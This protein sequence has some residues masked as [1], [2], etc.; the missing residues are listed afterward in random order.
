MAEKKGFSGLNDIFIEND[1][2]LPQNDDYKSGEQVGLFELDK[3]DIQGQQNIEATA[4]SAQA[5]EIDQIQQPSVQDDDYI[6][7]S[8]ANGQ[9]PQNDEGDNPKKGCLMMVAFIMFM[10]VALGVWASSESGSGTKPVNSQK[11][12]SD[13]NISKSQGKNLS[14]EQEARKRKRDFI[15]WVDRELKNNVHRDIG[16][17]IEATERES[18]LALSGK[19]I[20][21]DL[22]GGKKSYMT[23]KLSKRIKWDE[24]SESLTV[25]VITGY[26]D[27]KVCTY[28]SQRSGKVID[29]YQRTAK[30]TLLAYPGGRIIG[31]AKVK[32]EMPPSSVR[33]KSVPNAIYGKSED[34]IL[35]WANA[36]PKIDYE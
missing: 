30:I 28:R 23:D 13:S 22:Q 16:A 1:Q 3:K 9:L 21:W 29:G 20:I 27:E 15:N 25:A 26:D 6:S 18:M 14:P 5:Q 12:T 11:P 33:M 32:G 31:R 36:F 19:L 17:N 35:K 24:N 10:F 7:I 34:S 4:N 2:M 8:S